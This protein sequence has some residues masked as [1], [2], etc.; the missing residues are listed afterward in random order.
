MKGVSQDNKGIQR[1]D[2]YTCHN[3]EDRML[4]GWQQAQVHR[5]RRPTWSIQNYQKRVQ[6]SAVDNV[7]DEVVHVVCLLCVHCVD[8]IGIMS[9]LILGPNGSSLYRLLELALAPEVAWIAHESSLREIG[10][11]CGFGATLN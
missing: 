10:R 3:I 4:D 11:Q 2:S 9:P 6:C 1:Q 7:V 5:I 8:S